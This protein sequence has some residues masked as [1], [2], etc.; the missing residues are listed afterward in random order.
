MNET[1]KLKKEIEWWED[2]TEPIIQLMLNLIEDYSIKL[3]LEHKEFYSKNEYFI[4][5]RIAGL[6]NS[7]IL[8]KIEEKYGN[9][10]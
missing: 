7:A 2:R 9:K 10:K 4:K 6:I 1:E 5:Y 8:D 3:K